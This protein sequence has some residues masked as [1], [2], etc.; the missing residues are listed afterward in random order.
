MGHFI[1]IVSLYYIL[2]GV[3]TLKRSVSMAVRAP[4]LK[5]GANDRLNL[6]AHW[7]NR[8]DQWL[9][10]TQNSQ[11]VVEETALGRVLHDSAQFTRV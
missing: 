5:P 1:G 8:N 6:N 10:P 2:M 11:T 3:K 9:A 4:G 7:T